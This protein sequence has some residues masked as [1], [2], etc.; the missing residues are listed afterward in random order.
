MSQR[1]LPFAAVVVWA[2]GA[3]DVRAS[4]LSGTY[5]SPLGRVAVVEDAEGSVSATVVDKDNPC[6]FAPG[7]AVF[8]GARLDQ[9][10]AGTFRV[11]R[12]GDGCSGVVPAD[13]ILVIGKGIL[14]GSVHVSAGGCRTPL[15]GKSITL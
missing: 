10:L 4:P 8:S 15:V 1:L 13:A 7:T 12:Q 6:G 5:A 14:A 9:S 2:L 3:A 11:C